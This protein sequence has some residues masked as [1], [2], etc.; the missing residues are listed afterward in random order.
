[1]SQHS[2]T[3]QQR[4]MKTQQNKFWLQTNVNDIL[5]PMM[6][7]CCQK[8]PNDK[9][10]FMIE[11]LEEKYGERASQG[12]KNN[13][14]FMRNEVKRLEAQVETHKEKIAKDPPAEEKQPEEINS[15]DE[16]DDDDDDDYVDILPEQ[17]A[18]RQ[19][20]GPRQSVSAEAFG[21]FNKK[22]DFKAR[23]VPKSEQAKEAIMDKIAKSFMFSGLDEDEKKIVVDAMEEKKTFKNECVIKEGDEGDCLYVVASG[24]LSCT[25]VFKGNTEPTFLKKYQPSEAFGELA[26]LYNAPR[27]ASITSDEEC[28]LYALDRQ[29]FNHIVKDAAIRKREK[30]EEFLKKIPLLETMD[31]YERSQVAEAFKDLNLKAGETIIKEGDEGRELYFLVSGEAFASKVLAPG[32]PPKEVKQYASG[33]YFGELALLRN[34]PRAASIIARTDCLCVSVDRHSFKRMLGPL[35]NILKRNIDL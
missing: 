13:L 7:A 3:S 5:E 6:L 27:A 24:T 14:D 17:L 31:D 10:V 26:L 16:T 34:E 11:Y 8:N 12:D 32:E 28:L 15:E 9:I 23:V 33:D 18:K 29:T 30:Y 4:Q 2:Q 22:E 21:Q 20:K 35:E 25:K 1:M 19:A